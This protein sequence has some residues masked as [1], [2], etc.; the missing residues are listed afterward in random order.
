MGEMRNSYKILFGKPEGKRQ[1]G[2]P[3][4]RWKDNIKMGPWKYGGKVGTGFIWLMI[5]TSSGLL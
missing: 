2:R 4:H 5:R 3:A 1:L